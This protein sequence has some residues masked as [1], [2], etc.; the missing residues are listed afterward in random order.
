[1]DSNKYITGTYEIDGDSII[2][3]NFKSGRDVVLKSVEVDGK[4][5]TLK[6]EIGQTEKGYR[7]SPATAEKVLPY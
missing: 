5:M 6:N 2:L 7:I 3:N 1:L 4:K